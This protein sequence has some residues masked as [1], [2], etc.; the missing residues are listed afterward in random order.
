M[1]RFSLNVLAEELRESIAQMESATAVSSDLG[2]GSDLDILKRWSSK[3]SYYTLGKKIEIP[4]DIPQPQKCM[5]FLKFCFI[6]REEL[7]QAHCAKADAEIA[8]FKNSIVEL[9]ETDEDP[10]E[11]EE[12][13]SV[14]IALMIDMMNSFE[15]IKAGL[16]SYYTMKADTK[17]GAEFVSILGEEFFKAMVL[18]IESKPFDNTLFSTKRLK[19]N[20]YIKDMVSFKSSV[21]KYSL[22]FSKSEE[23]TRIILTEG[24][25]KIMKSMLACFILCRLPVVIVEG[26]PPLY[27]GHFVSSV[28]FKPYLDYFEI[29]LG[30]FC[31]RPDVSWQ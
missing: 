23:T 1:S 19:S 31:I 28:K 7:Y 16:G 12:M 4:A 9:M 30:S 27:F 8:S 15:K 14:E 11:P 2:A 18:I 13:A 26:F 20:K 25:K 5:S 24:F 29:S 10:Q 22:M 21:E 3:V 6:K 17:E